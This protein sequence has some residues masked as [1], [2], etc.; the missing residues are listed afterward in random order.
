MQ[1]ELERLSPLDTWGQILFY[2]FCSR[3]LF[4]VG[5]AVVVQRKLFCSAG[6][7]FKAAL[8]LHK[9]FTLVLKCSVP[10]SNRNQWDLTAGVDS[11]PHVAFGGECVCVWHSTYS[12]ECA[13]TGDQIK[14]Q[15]QRDTFLNPGTRLESL[16]VVIDIKWFC[17]WSSVS[18]LTRWD[19]NSFGPVVACFMW[20][21]DWAALRLMD[22]AP[23][24][25]S[26]IANAMATIGQTEEPLV[27]AGKGRG[28]FQLNAPR[29][30]NPTSEFGGSFFIFS[31]LLTHDQEGRRA[32]FVPQL[33]GEGC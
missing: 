3:A 9:G 17:S 25:L 21:Y 16:F 5:R 18:S 8:F 7:L 6:I 30:R 32:F 15:I 19:E 27:H 26:Q 33:S 23:R 10:D 11:R 1:S 20:S 12:R 4:K 24:D 2:D 29:K 28:L 31:V 14:F 13:I 22:V